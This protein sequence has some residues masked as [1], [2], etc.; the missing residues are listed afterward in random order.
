[1]LSLSLPVRN[2][3]ADVITTAVGSNGIVDIYN[4]TQPAPGGT[5]TT[6]LARLTVAGAFA[7]TTTNGVMVVNAVTQ[8][9]SADN[10]GTPT[11][12]RVTTSAGVYV[13]D[14]TAG[15][16]GS[17]ADLTFDNTAFYATGV[18]Q[19]TSFTITEQN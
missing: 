4:G 3:R 15:P 6:R 10:T 14:G 19:I 8:D 18:V 1:M 11:W 2:A 16:T 7:P 17:G 5:V 13:M 9:S 12:F